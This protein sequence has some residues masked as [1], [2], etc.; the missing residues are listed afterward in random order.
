MIGIPC[1]VCLGGCSWCA[2]SVRSWH[3]QIGP[4]AI[5]SRDDDTFHQTLITY[6]R[7]DER[8]MET[9]AY[10]PAS[11]TL[12]PW[13][14][15]M[16]AWRQRARWYYWNI[17]YEAEIKFNVAS[18]GI[19]RM[20]IG[21]NVLSNMGDQLRIIDHSSNHLASVTHL[22]STDR[23]ISS[24]SDRIASLK[25]LKSWI[26]TMNIRSAVIFKEHVEGTVQKWNEESRL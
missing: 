14:I 16:Q 3:F 17:I 20:N 11:P 23:K 9:C 4:M 10:G 5:N 12:S 18:A 25:F 24:N 2:T 19:A 22:E 6:S 21:K 1:L 15:I 8:T 26:Y 13:L 7:A